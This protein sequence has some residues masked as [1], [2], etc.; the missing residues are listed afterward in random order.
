MKFSVWLS[1]FFVYAMLVALSS[2]SI[3][4]S[5]REL[6]DYIDATSTVLCDYRLVDDMGAGGGYIIFECRDSY[7]GV[8]IGNPD[9]PWGNSNGAGSAVS[10]A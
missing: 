2:V 1:R 7:G 6:D 5:A 8:W 4:A 3:T 9:D 10:N